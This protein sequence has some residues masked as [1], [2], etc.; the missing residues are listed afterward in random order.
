[1]T[2]NNP[3]SLMPPP[4]ADGLGVWS[5]EDGTPGTD[6]YDGAVDAAFVPADQD[7][8]GCLELLKTQSTQ[9]LRYM[10]QTPIREGYY[11]RVTARIKA[12]SG[13]FASVRIAGWPGDINGNPVGG[14]QETGPS[15]QLTT[16]GEVVTLSAVIGTGARDGV[17]LVWDTNVEF[18]HF[19]LD[20]TGA[21]GGVVRI[22]DLEILD[23]TA[24][25]TRDLLDWVDVL[26]FGAVGDGI[27]DD[28]AA[29]E[30]ADTAANGRQVLVPSGL[31]YLANNVT[32]ESPVRFEGNVLMPTNRRLSLRANYDLN[33]YIAAFGDEVEGFK[34]AFQALLNFTDHEMLDMNGRQIDVT[35]PIDMQ[36]AVENKTTFAIRRVIRNGTLAVQAGPAW[37]PDVVTSTASYSSSQSTKLTNVA[38][39]ANV[40]VGALVEG[41]GVGREIYV[42]SKNVGAG[43]L[44][45]S[46]PLWGAP[47]S[48]TYTFTRFKY[49][50]DFSGFDSLQRMQLSEIHIQCNGESSGVM[51]P[52]SGS[53]F[54]FNECFFSRPRHR[55]ITSVGTGCQGMQIDKCRFFSNESPL[56]TQHRTAIAFNANG[57]DVKLRSSW[58]QHFR[59]TAILAGTGNMLVAN[60]WFQGDDTP[61]SVRTAGVVFTSKNA[62]SVVTGNY[63][64]NSSIELNNEHDAAPDFSNEFG[65]GGLTLT[66][67]IF[68]VND[69][70]SWFRWIVLKPYGP[71]HFVQGLSVTGNTF[72]TINANIG[73]IEGIDTSIATMDFGRFRNIIFE[74]NTFNGVDQTTFNPV[75]LEF[76]QNTVQR[77]WVLNVGDY[78]PFGGFA[79]VVTAMAPEGP[80]RDASNNWIFGFPFVTARFGAAQNQVRLTW[81]E[82]CRGKVHVTARVDAPI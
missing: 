32:F 10:G 48:Q 54:D 43:E 82:P 79:R 57:N 65:F 63:I 22:E 24:N 13:A 30:A 34:R 66:G 20:L 14:Q 73:R 39:V 1:M 33:A 9:R 27:T 7:F 11:V 17:D 38:N 80:I 72:R 49:V 75:T 16:Y 44:T 3:F 69:S 78:L 12:I 4:F 50:L 77:D 52:P 6:T 61:G 55:A 45:I 56:G 19:G 18:G 35:A 47:G 74:A 46:Q 23:V 41:S 76:D 81:S 62:K 5:R 42:V 29:F 26:D 70:A 71:G 59:H 2:G 28:S 40:P 25:F 37:D 21:N 58:F 53:L 8:G 36:A 64:D 60:H 68:T 67:N 15:V 51:L 31:F